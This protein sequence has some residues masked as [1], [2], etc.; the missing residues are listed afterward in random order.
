MGW[1]RDR[2]KTY[3]RQGEVRVRSGERVML[4]LKGSVFAISKFGCY[5][6]ICI[7]NILHLG[8]QARLGCWWVCVVCGGGGGQ[9]QQGADG[10][11]APLL[12]AK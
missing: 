12:A 2:K 4:K 7:F 6:L 9:K 3:V 5:Q 10:A 11:P 8:G 1:R